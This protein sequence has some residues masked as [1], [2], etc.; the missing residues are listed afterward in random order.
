MLPMVQEDVQPS[1]PQVMLVRYG[2]MSMLGEFRNTGGVLARC[3]QKVIIETDRGMEIGEVVSVSCG[4]CAKSIGRD[5]VRRYVN[6]SGP[7]NCNFNA[8]KVLREA[9]AADVDEARHMSAGAGDMRRFC[10]ELADTMGLPM[11]VVDVEHIF[12]GER[13]VFYFQS[14]HR[15][16][17]RGLVKD[18]AQQYQTRI[19][20]RQI[21]ARDEARLLADYEICGRECCCKNFLKNLKP[22]NMRMAKTQKATLD[23]TKVSGRC[24]RLRCCLRY[25]NESYDELERKLPRMNSRVRVRG[26]ENAVARVIDRQILTQ[27]V[28]VWIEPD[29]GRQVVPVDD[30]LERNVKDA[31]SPGQAA[32]KAPQAADSSGG[33]NGGPGGNGGDGGNGGSEGGRRP[34]RRRPRNR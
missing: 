34:R 26:F 22:V 13:A 29:G 33:G 19:E 17:F 32:P 2:A 20:M 7:E 18:L 5:M 8:G 28:A 3:G 25:E 4:A 15:V 10:Q 30:I 6:A 12:G 9:T 24:G 31:S 11:L 14:E 1:P 23:P 21:G 16:D 27:L